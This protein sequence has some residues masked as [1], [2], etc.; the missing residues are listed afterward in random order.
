MVTKGAEAYEGFA[1]IQLRYY[2]VVVGDA[3]SVT[4]AVSLNIDDTTKIQGANTI[5]RY[6][7]QGAVVSKKVL[8]NGNEVTSVDLTEED[9]VDFRIKINQYGEG[10]IY[11]DGEKIAW[12]D[13]AQCFDF[14]NAKDINGPFKIETDEKR[15][16][17]VKVGDDAIPAGEY[18]IDFTVKINKALHEYGKES[19]NTVG[20]TVTIR[21]KAKLTID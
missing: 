12:D 17:I 21:R 2:A 5:L 18:N 7:T 20:N 4:N 8:Y 6:E 10:N 11:K 9:T 1:N 16:Y 14:E 13:L 15:L 19:T 3:N